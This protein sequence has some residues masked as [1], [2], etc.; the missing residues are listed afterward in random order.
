MKSDKKNTTNTG[1][2]PVANK[3]D[4]SGSLMKGSQKNHGEYR[5]PADMQPWANEPLYLIIARWC[6]QQ[7]RWINRN[8]VA[9]AFYLTERKASLQLAYINQKKNRIACRTR[10]HVSDHQGHYHNEIW[11][12]HI[13]SSPI[14][15][16]VRSSSS[17]RRS[18]PSK[19][20]PQTRRV[21]SGMTGHGCLWETI[22]RRVRGEQ[23][24]E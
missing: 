13:L 18:E 1:A 8:D 2:S 24:D 9:A 15:N 3:G 19:S 7:N 12:D 6:L 11:V 23:G 22:L 10:I 4:L 21:G 5:L 14:E 17:R 16:Y 20:S